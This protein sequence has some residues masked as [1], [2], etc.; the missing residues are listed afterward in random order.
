MMY[1]RVNHTATLLASGKVLVVGGDGLAGT[2]AELYDPVTGAWAT[3]GSPVT[4]TR[5]SATILGSGQVL[6]AG[7][8]EVTTGTVATAELYDPATETWTP[9]GSLLLARNGQG[10]V[11]LPSGQV[12]VAGGYSTWRSVSDSYVPDAELYDPNTGTWTATASMA[13]GRACMPLTL[14]KSGAV[15]VAGGANYPIGSLSSAE[16]YWP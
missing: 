14:L 7:G 10:A 9:T 4:R 16:L 12:L 11:R 2:P 8:G 6:V 15:L 1:G 5:H 13:T 3:T